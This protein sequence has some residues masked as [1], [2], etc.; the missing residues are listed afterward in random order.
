MYKYLK[1]QTQKIKRE[2]KEKE[3]NTEIYISGET[4]IYLLIRD[5]H[6]EVWICFICKFMLFLF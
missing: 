3:S 1:K 4:I 6:F 2:R 5:A